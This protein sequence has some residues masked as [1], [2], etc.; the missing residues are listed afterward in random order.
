MTTGEHTPIRDQTSVPISISRYSQL[1]AE[2]KLNTWKTNGNHDK[3]VWVL[4]GGARLS[5]KG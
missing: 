2:K 5:W 1:S 3:L 4:Q